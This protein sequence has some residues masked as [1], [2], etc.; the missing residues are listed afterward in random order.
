M[1]DLASCSSHFRQ[2]DT[3]VG[4]PHAGTGLGLGRFLPPMNE[5]KEACSPYCYHL[6]ASC[7]PKRPMKRILIVD[8]NESNRY[9]LHTLL[10]GHDYTV[11]SAQH[12][13]EALARA[14]QSPPDIVISDLLMPVM[15]GFTFLRH[16]KADDRLN[17]APFIVYTATY[18]EPEDERLALSLGA[19]AFIFKPA[20][21][22]DFL[23][24]L[25]ELQNK[26]TSAVPTPENDPVGGDKK[27]LLKVYSEILV[28]KL[29]E[30]TLQLGKTNR[31][32]EQDI[33][34]RKLLETSL[35][36][37]QQALQI[38]TL[39]LE[40]ANSELKQ[41]SHELQEARDVL[42]KRV[43]ERTA[44]HKA[45]NVELQVEINERRRIER[46]L[47]DKNVELQNAAK[48]KDLFLAHMSHELRTPLNG[49]IGFAEFL[50][51][52]KPGTVN[53]KQKEYLEDILNSGRH[54]LHLINDVLDLAKVEAGKMDLYPEIFSLPKAI[55]E[56]C[57]VTKPM[58]QKKGIRL[59]VNVAPGLGN[60]T[61]D[62]PKFKQVLYNLLSNAVKFTGDG[63]KVQIRAAIYDAHRFKLVVQDTGIGIKTE[64]IHRLFK[65]FG[66]LESSATCQ[67][68]GTGLGLALT[69]KILESQG[70]EVGV[71]SEAGKGSSFTVVL[72]LVAVKVNL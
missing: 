64:D 18:T 1:A 51:D 4:H 31:A 25:R 29:E 56:V 5:L 40:Q 24:K 11:D 45:T 66:Q 41:R 60:V 48:A 52:G 61:L 46:D 36:D 53:P 22:H 14:R 15:D 12:G 26:A 57:A 72:P 13:A 70:G 23:A 28:R 19:D 38:R 42:E 17:Q 21:P 55:E 68:K 44:Q 32:L 16:W 39:N 34:K 47:D 65:E 59:E 71:E 50:V 69:R 63:G 33:A 27:A 8:D 9:Y 35:H 20:E 37:A 62:Q 30:K 49:I 58:V 54:L 67:Y 7:D 2:I 3:G 10:T 6:T 43:W